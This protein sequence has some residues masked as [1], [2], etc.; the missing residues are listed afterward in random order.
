MAGLELDMRLRKNVE[1][2]A[3]TARSRVESRI[4][5][6]EEEVRELIALRFG[7]AA[8][9]LHKARR[10]L[11]VEEQV[12]RKIGVRSLADIEEAQKRLA[13]LGVEAACV[14]T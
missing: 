12:A 4:L 9:E 11:A 13:E 6:A 8:T 10:K 1:A 2:K 7:I 5:G 3:S 14:L